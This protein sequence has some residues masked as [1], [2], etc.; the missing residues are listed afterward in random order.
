M[1][2]LRERE[3]R[4]TRLRQRLIEGRGGQEAREGAGEEQDPERAG[5]ADR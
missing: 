2:H 4:L 5:P 1:R 3:R